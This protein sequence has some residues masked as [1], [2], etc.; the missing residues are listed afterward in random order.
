MSALSPGNL[1]YLTLKI[2]FLIVLTRILLREITL[3]ISNSI[4]AVDSETVGV[5]Y[6]LSTTE[7]TEVARFKN[8]SSGSGYLKISSMYSCKEICG[9]LRQPTVANSSKDVASFEVMIYFPEK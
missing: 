9:L 4:E 1:R 3:N 7:I 6:P 2:G 8:R 5:V